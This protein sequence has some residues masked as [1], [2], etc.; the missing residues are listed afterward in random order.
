MLINGSSCKSRYL[1]DYSMKAYCPF[2]KKRANGCFVDLFSGGV[3]VASILTCTTE[4]Q[5]SPYTDFLS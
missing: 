4:L 1:L 2:R 5:P 3:F